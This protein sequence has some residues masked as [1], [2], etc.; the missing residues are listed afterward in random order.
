M[1]TLKKLIESAFDFLEDLIGVHKPEP[2]QAILESGDLTVTGTGSVEIHLQH[3]PKH[4]FV[5][6]LGTCIP[7]PCSPTH[8]D[9]LCYE[10]QEH[11][12]MHGRHKTEYRLSIQY[13]VNETRAIRWSTVE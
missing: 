1:N 8:S 4:Y 3:K 9:S 10:V 13:D 11:Y 2:H 5:H 12:T 6:F 7:H